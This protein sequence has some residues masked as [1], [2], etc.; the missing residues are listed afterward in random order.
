MYVALKS[1]KLPFT[2]DGAVLSCLTGVEE[3]TGSLKEEEKE[4]DKKEEVEDE[5]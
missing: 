2:A 5:E 3:I 1:L 4:E